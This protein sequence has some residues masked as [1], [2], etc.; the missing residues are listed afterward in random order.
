M[1]SGNAPKTENVVL[2]SSYIARTGATESSGELTVCKKTHVHD[3]GKVVTITGALYTSIQ[4][5]MLTRV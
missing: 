5:T 2:A 1:L 3:I 4:N